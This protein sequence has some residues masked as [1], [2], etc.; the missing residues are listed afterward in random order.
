MELDDSPASAVFFTR[1]IAPRR[2]H[3]IRTLSCG[4]G[5][6]GGRDPT[7]TE[8][9]AMARHRALVASAI[10][11]LVNLTGIIA[12]L[13]DEDTHF[14]ALRDPLAAVVAHFGPQLLR[15]D[16]S[17]TDPMDPSLD[18]VY[19]AN[20]LRRLP[21]LTDLSLSDVAGGWS[22]ELRQLADSVRSLQHLK[23]LAFDSCDGIDG[24]LASP[25]GV[26][27]EADDWN[28]P[29]VMLSV[30]N[31]PHLSLVNLQH[32]T[33]RWQDTLEEIVF[34]TL[35][36][37]L[38]EAPKEGFALPGVTVLTLDCRPSLDVLRA[39]AGCHNLE[40][41]KLNNWTRTEADDELFDELRALLDGWT[42]LD[43]IVVGDE[44]GGD[45]MC[46][47]FWEDYCDDRELDLSIE[48]L[49]D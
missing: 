1:T 2:G 4:L 30:L 34:S 8:Q 33:V 45:W 47:M 15:L 16:L 37:S 28:P 44:R 24:S 19:V 35:H 46:K 18:P 36:D 41:L 13:S 26:T 5:S 25:A 39:F 17:H 7:R 10:P 43:E 6:K 23:T 32:L 9:V 48:E 11:H 12:D 20:L 21:N 3:H 49:L 40:V 27:N 22:H 31:C 38:I 14:D 42:E 29:L